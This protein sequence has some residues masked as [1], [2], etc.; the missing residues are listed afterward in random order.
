MR[1]RPTFALWR[2][3]HAAN[4]R[5]RPGEFRAKFDSRKPYHW[6]VL[7]FLDYDPALIGVVQPTWFMGK[8]NKATAWGRI[9]SHWERGPR[10]HFL[11]E[12]WNRRDSDTYVLAFSKGGTF[13]TAYSTTRADVPAPVFPLAPKRARTLLRLNSVVPD[14]L[15]REITEEAVLQVSP[16]NMVRLNRTRYRVW[17]IYMPLA[18]SL[19]LVFR[20]EGRWYFTKSASDTSRLILLLCPPAA[21]QGRL[22]HSKAVRSE[23]RPKKIR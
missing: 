20:D 4:E 6:T 13:V 16:R 8:D 10:D 5:K 19:A 21:Q 11:V 2:R 14:T 15:P 1:E 3:T 7:T 9:L 18:E 17:D 23:A 12:A 22:A